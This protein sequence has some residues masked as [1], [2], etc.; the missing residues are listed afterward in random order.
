VLRNYKAIL[1][2]NSICLATQRTGTAS[3]W[4]SSRW[5]AVH[6]TYCPL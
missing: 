5:Y 2:S 4:H 1:K 3:R 6:I